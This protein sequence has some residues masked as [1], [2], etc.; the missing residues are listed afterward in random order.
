MKLWGNC[1]TSNTAINKMQYLLLIL[2]IVD[3]IYY[4]KKCKI[5]KSFIIN[6]VSVAITMN[7]V[8]L[9]IRFN[10]ILDYR[11][12]NTNTILKYRRCVS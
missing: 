12:T 6:F 9:T 4:L 7:L 10:C 3:Y 11:P 5:S 8:D 2:V 1:S